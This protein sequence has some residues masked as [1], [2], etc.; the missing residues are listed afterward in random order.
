M[1]V[2]FGPNF[3]VDVNN[4]GTG[5]IIVKVNHVPH[6]FGI[7]ETLHHDFILSYGSVFSA[8]SLGWYYLDDRGGWCSH[9]G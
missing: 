9:N 4:L 8:A 2:E 3:H 7:L 5:G 6:P 1:T